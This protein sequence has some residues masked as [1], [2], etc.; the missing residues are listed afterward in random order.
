MQCSCDKPLPSVIGNR[1][2]ENFIAVEIEGE[3]ADPSPNCDHEH[4]EKR[5][6]PPEV[7]LRFVF[8]NAFL[9]KLDRI[10]AQGTLQSEL[11]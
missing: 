10:C 8:S 1:K 3:L 9:C 5:E 2:R 6:V 4:R 11:A 7:L